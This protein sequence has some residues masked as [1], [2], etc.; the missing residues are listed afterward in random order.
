[1][2]PLSVPNISGNE[3]KY[4]TDCIET[5]WVSSVGEYV[6]KLEDRVKELV[7][8]NRAVACTSGTAALFLGLKA[9]GVK[10]GQEVIVPALT[11]IASAN[12]VRHVGAYPA[13]LDVDPT[14]WQLDITK[15]QHFLSDVCHVFDDRVI[16]KETGR[17]VVAIMPVHLLGNM[18]DMDSLMA[19]ADYYGLSVIEDAAESLG[20]AYENRKAGS[21]GDVGVFSFNGNKTFTAGGGG[22]LVT[23][24]EEIADHAQRLSTQAKADPVEYIHNEVGYNF[25]LT[26]TQAAIALAQL[27]RYDE[28]IEKKKHIAATYRRGLKRIGKF[29]RSHSW[30][31]CVHWLSTIS[32][33]EGV[34]SREVMR[35]LRTRNIQTRPL[36][37]PLTA[38][39]AMI[40]S[41]AD[42]AP[43]AHKLFNSCLS[44]PSSTSITDEELYEV[45]RAVRD[46]F[47]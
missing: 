39:K 17:Q 19:L 40:G 4:V 24:K 11:F 33:N 38:S 36:W 1:M 41:Y 43:V 10:S 45:V 13:F 42:Q 46:Y 28:F 47:A 16:N 7:G 21:W 37:Q 6:F 22:V 5:G 30:V 12:A 2:I 14:T 35:Y 25:R 9:L 18:V 29:M 23:N 15:L 27:E 3:L 32:F 20:A 34:S 31:D 44:L 8:T 26:N